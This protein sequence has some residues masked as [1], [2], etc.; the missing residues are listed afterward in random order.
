MLQFQLQISSYD[1]TRYSLTAVATRPPPETRPQVPIR[2]GEP[3]PP[4]GGGG[5]DGPTGNNRAGM[6]L[7]RLLLPVEAKGKSIKGLEEASS[8]SL[9]ESGVE[10]DMV[11]PVVY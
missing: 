2:D 7:L 9:T 8:G 10:I 1:L 4:G 11:A 3:T 5:E 6:E